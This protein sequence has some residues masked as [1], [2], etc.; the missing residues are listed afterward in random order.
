MLAPSVARAQDS[1]TFYDVKFVCAQRGRTASEEVWGAVHIGAYHTAINI[2]NPG[3]DS[4][5]IRTRVATTRV[6]PVPGGLFTGPTATLPGA[7]ALEIDCTDILRAADTRDFVKGFVTVASTEPLEIVAVYTAG[8]LLNTVASIDVE[9]VEPRAGV[10]RGSGRC[11]DLALGRIERPVPNQ[12][13]QRTR[14]TFNVHN[15][16]DIASGSYDVSMED[17]NGTGPQRIVEGNNQTSLNGGGMAT[18]TL[19]F[20]YLISG[21]ANLAAIMVMVDPKNEIPECREDNNRRTAGAV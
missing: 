9:R 13:T 1:L 12:N 16:G 14:V 10:A 21:N 3:R 4:A 6:P 11:I 7:H 5:R 18:I 2:L 15:L 20:S 8:P 19:E 17:P